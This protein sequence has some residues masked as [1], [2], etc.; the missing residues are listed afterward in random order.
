[1]SRAS[2]FPRPS[3][4]PF[5]LWRLLPL[6]RGPPQNQLT[7]SLP[8]SKFIHSPMH[9][10]TRSFISV[11]KSTLPFIRSLI[12]SFSHWF[13]HS[14]TDACTQRWQSQTV[15]QLQGLA[16]RGAPGKVSAGHQ[17]VRGQE[18]VVQENGREVGSSTLCSGRGRGD[19]KRGPVHHPQSRALRRVPR[20]VGGPR[21]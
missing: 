16:D 18:R 3:R 17:A 21:H 20:T 2:P 15:G 19:Q 8:R 4:P 7:H 14:F 5:L 12:H 6:P 1:M 10:W 11:G 13:I 9:A